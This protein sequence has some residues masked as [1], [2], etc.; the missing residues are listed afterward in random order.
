MLVAESKDA[1][2]IVTLRFIQPNTK[3]IRKLAKH[4]WSGVLG[5]L[6]DVKASQITIRGTPTLT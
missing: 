4:M 5:M 3:R 1:T 2:S 6:K